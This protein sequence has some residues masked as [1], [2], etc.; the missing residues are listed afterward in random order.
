MR[1]TSY[2]SLGRRA[3]RRYQEVNVEA[4][5]RTPVCWDRV[6][7][8]ATCGTFCRGAAGGPG[9]VLYVHFVGSG[10]FTSDD[11]AGSPNV[12]CTYLGPPS[13]YLGGDIICPSALPT[14]VTC[15]SGVAPV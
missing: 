15:S 6:E 4:Q 10:G 13:V 11:N 8:A 9:I 3:H 12:G 2:E 1:R 7:Q 5:R 14:G